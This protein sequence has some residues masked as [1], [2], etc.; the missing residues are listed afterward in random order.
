VFAALHRATL[1]TRCAFRTKQQRNRFP[2]PIVKSPFRK[3][4]V[5]ELR[6]IWP[7]RLAAVVEEGEQHASA[8][9]V[10]GSRAAGAA[11]LAGLVAAFL[12]QR[13]GVGL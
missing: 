13:L 9:G 1:Q 2:K 6:R 3:V 5:V 10:A 12:I 11:V 4:H 7:K 8:A